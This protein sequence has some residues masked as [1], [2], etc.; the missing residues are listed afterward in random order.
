MFI[1]RNIQTIDDA[2]INNLL[3]AKVLQALQAKI[4]ESKDVNTFKATTKDET[5]FAEHNIV[6]LGEITSYVYWMLGSAN[7][8]GVSTF[9]KC[10]SANGV[11]YFTETVNQNRLLTMYKSFD[12]FL[13]EFKM[14]TRTAY[15]FKTKI[16][17]IRLPIMK[18]WEFLT[19]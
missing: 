6:F 10:L 11:E 14:E 1:A 16:C 3:S 9:Y 4:I 2:C 8:L 5:L 12:E 15:M 7:M 13:S 19:E 18:A 17:Y